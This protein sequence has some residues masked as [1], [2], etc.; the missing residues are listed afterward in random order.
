MPS[1]NFKL[2]QDGGEANES[3]AGQRLEV[4]RVWAVS[5]GATSRT[6]RQ[7]PRGNSPRHE[8]YWIEPQIWTRW[9]CQ[10]LEVCDG[11]KV[12]SA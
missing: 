7:A 1:R 8:S 4:A 10:Y 6:R 9:S 3:R 11:K 2:R 5:I 12:R